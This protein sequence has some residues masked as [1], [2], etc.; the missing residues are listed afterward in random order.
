MRPWRYTPCRAVAAHALTGAV[1]TTP[2]ASLAL[3]YPHFAAR[4]RAPY[5]RTQLQYL[6]PGACV[7]SVLAEWWAP[8]SFAPSPVNLELFVCSTSP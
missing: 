2:W 7:L 6:T 8:D 5:R 1:V 4:C 3:S